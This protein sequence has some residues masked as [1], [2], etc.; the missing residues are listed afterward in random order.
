VFFTSVKVVKKQGKMEKLRVA[1]TVEDMVTCCTGWEEKK[2]MV[3][4][5]GRCEE[6]RA[7]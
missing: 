1:E 6:T 2:D 7:Q 4:K 3:E 5:L